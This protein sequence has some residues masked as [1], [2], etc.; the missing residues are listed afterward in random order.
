[1]GGSIHATALVAPDAVVGDD[2]EIGAY[3]VLG[4]GVTIGARTRIGPHVVI[5]GPTRVGADNV[6]H[7]IRLDRR[8]PAGQEIQGRA[9]AARDRRPQRDPRVRDAQSRHHPG[10]RRHA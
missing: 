4:A 2:V 10:S 1:M 3:S 5:N 6:I 8:R 9:D 7:A